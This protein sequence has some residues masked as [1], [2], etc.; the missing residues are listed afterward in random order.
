MYENAGLNRLD[1]VFNTLSS[2]DII[3]IMKELKKMRSQLSLD[4]CFFLSKFY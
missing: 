3:N 2:C 4:K 1:E